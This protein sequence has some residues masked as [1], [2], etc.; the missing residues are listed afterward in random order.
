M[1]SD[2]EFH[3]ASVGH[4]IG[5]ILDTMRSR[6]KLTALQWGAYVDYIED[7]ERMHYALFLLDKLFADLKEEVDETAAP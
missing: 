2:A 4:G 5:E 7:L 1:T 6:T 3:A